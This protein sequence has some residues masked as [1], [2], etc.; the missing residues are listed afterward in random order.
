[1]KHTR[2]KL[3]DT[4]IQ[5]NVSLEPGELAEAKKLALDRLAKNVKAAGFRPGK[6]PPKIAEKHIAGEELHNAIVDGAVNKAIVDTFSENDVQPLERPA[7]EIKKYVPDELLE[8]TAE[9]E[10]LPEIKLGNYKQLKVTPK[11]IT[12]AKKDIDEV[13]ERM[14]QGFAEKETVE[15]A[16]KLG[17]E[18]LI[19]F[20]GTDKKGDKV[21]GASGKD[22]PLTLGSQSFI[23]G[24]EE[25]LVG[26]K[27]GDTFELPLTFPK[28]YHASHLAGTKIV[29]FVTVKKVQQVDKPKVDDAFAKKCGPFKTV[30]ELRK[31]I[32]A[33]LAARKKEEAEHELKDKLVEQLVKTSVIPVPEVLVSDQEANLK[34]DMQQNLMS[35]GMTLEQYLTEQK[36]TEEQWLEKELKPAAIAR[37]QAGLALAE[38][39]K[40]EKIEASKQE[41]DARH[42][43]MKQ[44]YGND[45]TVIAQLDS[46]EVRRD[47]ANRVLT[48]KTI[49]RLLELN[50]KK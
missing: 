39:T 29:F 49:N 13:I 10:I 11:K 6:V 25:G 12:V 41:L 36:L 17:D 18:V 44:Q 8:F 15:R 7:V 20:D 45:P 46:P 26:K 21:A 43:E 31:D 50:T 47:L 4:K 38:L 48:E 2:K 35:R 24:F 27:T 34:R 1:M 3:S 23:P 22:Y 40:L 37:V 28:D 5:F 30:A 32:K 14:Q 33:E 9:A 42:T 19:D 16:A